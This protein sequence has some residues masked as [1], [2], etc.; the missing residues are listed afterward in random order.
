MILLLLSKD[1][2]EI[3]DI[4]ISMILEQ[5]LKFLDEMAEMDLDIASEF[6]A[7]ASH[8][9]YIKTKMLLSGGEEV[10]ELEQLISSLEELHRG[11]IYMQIKVAAQAL[12]AVYTRDGVMMASPPEYYSPD[13][14]Y[15]YYHCSEELFDAILRVIGSQNVLLGGIDSLEA[16]YPQR[17]EFTIPEMIHG[18]IDRLKQHGQMPVAHLLYK[19]GT[20]TEL[21]ATLIAILELCKVGS[22]L[23]MGGQDE[24]TIAYTGVGRDPEAWGDD[25]SQLSLYSIL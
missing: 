16:A 24:L 14:E 1:K 23:L 2:I 7:M 19:A 25:H 13:T 12:A 18:I 9:T 10:S 17:E 22:V 8:L 4:S 6:V 20:R 3:R 15:K 11:D 21:I 5:Y